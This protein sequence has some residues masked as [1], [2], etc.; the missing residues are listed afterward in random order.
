MAHLVFLSAQDSSTGKQRRVVERV[1]GKWRSSTLSGYL[2]T[3]DDITYRENFRMNRKTFNKLLGLL[4]PTSFAMC[5]EARFPT[6]VRGNKRRS[7]QSI[8]YARAHTDPPSTRYK[9]AVCLYAMAQGGRFKLI[10]DAASLGKNTVR[11]WMTAFCDAILQ[12]VRPIY[13]PG[14]AFSSADRAAVQGQF[15]SRRGF[16]NVTLACDGSH[17]PY[18]PLGGKKVKMQYRNYKGWTSILAVAF[19]VCGLLLQVL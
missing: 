9:L 14:T 17:I 16:P 1:R 7:P 15:A 2:R 11:K 4:K 6:P 13:M 19:V 18:H 3:G 10:G 5:D 8:A 12:E